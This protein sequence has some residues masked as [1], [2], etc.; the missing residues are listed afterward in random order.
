MVSMSKAYKMPGFDVLNLITLLSLGFVHLIGDLVERTLPSAEIAQSSASGGS[1]ELLV[2]DTTGVTPHGK[3]SAV[4]GTAYA[5][6]SADVQGD[7][8]FMGL[9]VGQI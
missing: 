3:V 5:Y 1:R 6:V 8:L 9:P 2:A 7:V 4:P